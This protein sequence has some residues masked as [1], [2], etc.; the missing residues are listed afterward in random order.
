MTVSWCRRS[1]ATKPLGSYGCLVAGPARIIFLSCYAAT[2]ALWGI[3]D[4]QRWRL[5]EGMAW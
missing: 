3:A 4:F 1:I 2:S 5:P